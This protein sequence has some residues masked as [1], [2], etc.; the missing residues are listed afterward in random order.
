MLERLCRPD[1]QCSRGFASTV[2]VLSGRNEVN[3]L[4]ITRRNAVRELTDGSESVAVAPRCA[5]RYAG[6]TRLLD[7]ALVL[8]QTVGTDVPGRL[9]LGVGANPGSGRQPRH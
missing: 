7:G 4:G 3:L 2:R 9:P 5:P 6:R 8:P 1:A